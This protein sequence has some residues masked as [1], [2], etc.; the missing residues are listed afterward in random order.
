VRPSRVGGV[1]L[2]LG[3]H[4]LGD[5][6]EQ[7]RL[8]RCVPVKDHRVPAQGAGEAAHGQRV[9]PVAV[10][11]LQRGGQHHIPGDLAT[12]VGGGVIDGAVGWRWAHRSGTFSPE[13]EA[14]G[15]RVG[16]RVDLRR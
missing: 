4:G 8:V 5:A 10:D 2:E 6:V 13:F 14:H 7:G 15:H 1:H 16:A 11:D 3:E 9:D 12:P